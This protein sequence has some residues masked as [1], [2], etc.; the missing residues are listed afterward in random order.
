[1]RRY[2]L[3]GLMMLVAVFGAAAA[4]FGLATTEL[5]PGLT[6]TDL[7]NTLLGSGVAISNVSYTGVNRAAGTFG[8]G[9]GSIG[10]ASGVVL[11]TGNIADVVGPNSSAYTSTENGQ[12]GDA[13]L[14]ALI[15]GYTTHDATVLEFDFV[16]LTGVITFDYVFGSDEYNE[17]VNTAY[18]DVFGFFI[19]GVNQALI[20]G[21][22]TA[23]AINNVNGGR[24]FGTNASNPEYYR[25]NDCN[26]PP[27]GCTIDTEL[28]GL[29]VVLTV[30]AYVNPGETNH[31]KLA[32]ADTDDELL[33]SDVFIEE[34]S[35]RAAELVLLPL[36]ETNPTGTWHR[37]TATPTING[38]PV[39]GTTVMFNII[40]GPHAGTTGG[41]V[42]NMSGQAQWMYYGTAPGTDAIE[43]TAD[44]GGSVETS[45]RAYK[46]WRTPQALPWIPL[47]LDD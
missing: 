47:L 23:V 3:G 35:F 34:G 27:G 17:F 40:A 25:N 15:P 12:P 9:A 7:A 30:T 8:D 32:I 45:N 16:P 22:T 19:N 26:D 39:P 2:V 4:S 42:T 18:N 13:D 5:G 21:T 37:L 36:L 24:P 1:M 6:P 10:P 33:D 44:I 38:V 29:T 41:A 11:S 20:P 46:T 31:I 28:D 14:D 43:A